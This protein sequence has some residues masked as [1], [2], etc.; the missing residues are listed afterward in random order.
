M[1]S[2]YAMLKQL[3]I[4]IW[5]PRLG[6]TCMSA[7]TVLAG[8]ILFVLVTLILGAVQP[9][10]NP[11]Y[12]TVSALVWGRFGW[13][14]TIVF[15]LFG[16]L[17]CIFT[18]RFYITFGEKGKILNAATLLLLLNGFGFFII[19]IFPTQPQGIHRL[20]HLYTSQLMALLFTGAL[21]LLLPNLRKHPGWKNVFVYT[22]ITALISLSLIILG[23]I[24][25]LKVPWMGLYE[26]I[27]LLNGFIW[28]EVIAIKLLKSCV[29]QTQRPRG[30]I[31]PA[32]HP[33]E[34]YG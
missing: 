6:L 4:N 22:L 17:M 29:L 1:C 12:R 11:I 34:L 14:Q 3:R 2:N 33:P 28:I 30:R 24:V 26:R 9:D 18:L 7:I 20:V 19:A 15:I 16:F 27:F 8:P 23:A 21:L 13:L 31:N 32:P 25:A 5:H 10:Y